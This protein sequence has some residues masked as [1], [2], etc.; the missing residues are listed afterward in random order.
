MCT[1]LSQG[2]FHISIRTSK[3]DARADE[4]IHKIV[5]GKGTGGGHYTY[6]GGQIPLSKSTK[7]EQAG[8]EKLVHR[9][10]LKAIGDNA[11]PSEQLI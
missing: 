1:G 6:A 2:K 9:R 4:I 5:A 8:L 11:Q 3:E 10:F 7:S